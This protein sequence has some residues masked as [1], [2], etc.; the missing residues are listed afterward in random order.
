MLKQ[1]KLILLLCL[2]DVSSHKFYETLKD[3]I[4][5]S[6][7]TYL[8]SNFYIALPQNNTDFLI[9]EL[10]DI[11]NPFSKNYANYYNKNMITKL[12]TP[13]DIYRKPVLNWLAF[14][15]L[16]VVNDNGDSLYVNGNLNSI[17]KALNVKMFRY[18]NNKKT[19]YRSIIPYEIPFYLEKN[20]IFIEGISNPIYK[21]SVLKQISKS[22]SHI[23]VDDNCAGKESIYEKYNITNDLDKYYN[24]SVC[25]IEYQGQSG[26]TQDDLQLNQQLNSHSLSNITHIVGIDTEPDMESQLDMQMMGNQIFNNTD[27]WFWDETNWLYSLA[28]NMS[29]TDII[30]DIISMS[31]GWREDDQCTVINCTNITSQTYINRVN[32]EYIKLGLRGVSIVTASGDAG[33]PGR[34]NED[35]VNGSSVHA[36]YPGASPW[37]TSVGGTFIVSNNQTR[38]W[39]TPLCKDNGCFTGT[40]ERVTNYNY[41]GWTSGGGFSKYTN[42]STYGWQVR[43]VNDYLASGVPLPSEFA[44]HGRAYPDV[45]MVGHSC[46][47]I[48]NS[49]FFGVDGTSCSSPLFATVLSILNEY[50]LSRGKRKLGFA[51]PL[52]YAMYYSN[53]PVFN[54]ITQGNNSCTEY[55][56][57]DVRDD[58]GSDFGY[59]ASDGYDP[60]YGLGTPNVQR[61]KE[62]LDLYL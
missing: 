54:D 36:I 57:C 11:S 56:C 60:V 50:Q 9:Q 20:I 23:D 35:C 52:L 27:I 37:V 2:N 28:V 15:N 18:S 26:F 46:P 7:K 32:I 62:W 51:S 30:P 45:S 29:N 31:W 19:I 48:V 59:L 42:R 5:P 49:A 13:N 21:R 40:E 61:M 39:T 17:E 47:V 38:N 44:K 3:N 14:S 16:T 41:V 12:V 10:L 4:T 24:S 22:K 1:L 43:A 58:G 53:F 8:E 55:K 25:S 34:T 6:E 33:A